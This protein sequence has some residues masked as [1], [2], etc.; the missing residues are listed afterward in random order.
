[1]EYI[2]SIINSL[3]DIKSFIS[4]NQL[5]ESALS[6]IQQKGGDILLMRKEA[7]NDSLFIR[8][9]REHRLFK[10]WFAEDYS[11][12]EGDKWKELEKDLHIRLIETTDETVIIPREQFIQATDHILQRWLNETTEDYPFVVLI[13][14]EKDLG[15]STFIRY[16]I[17]RALNH[18]NSTYGLTYF[19]C[20]I[21]QC[22]FTIGGC[23]SY[24]NLDTPLFGPPCSHMQSNLKPNR[25][26]YYGLVSPQTSPVRYLQYIDQLRRLWSI[27][28]K[29]KAKRS[30]VLINTMGWGTGKNKRD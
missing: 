7:K 28:Q 26:L 9:I 23:L 8:T 5:A 14:G 15:K 10:K 27:D 30:M 16:L 12:S 21:G 19:D 11:L 24:M 6:H 1:M 18:I 25:L 22:E 2:P 20:D 3:H 13:C 29:K 17:N 4:D